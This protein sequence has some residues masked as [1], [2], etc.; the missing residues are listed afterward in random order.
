MNVLMFS[1]TGCLLLAWLASV[2]AIRRGYKKIVVGVCEQESLHRLKKLKLSYTLFDFQ[3]ITSSTTKAVDLIAPSVGNHT[4]CSDNGFEYARLNSSDSALTRFQSW[5]G[6]VQWMCSI[7]HEANVPEYYTTDATN[8]TSFP[9]A[10]RVWPL[11]NAFIN[12]YTVTI[13]NDRQEMIKHVAP[14]KAANLPYVLEE[15]LEHVT[16]GV[17]RLYG[18]AFQGKLLSLRC[19]KHIPPITVEQNP[20]HPERGH[21]RLIACGKDITAILHDMF[22]KAGDYSGPFCA[23]IMLDAQRRPHFT[24]FHA[25]LCQEVTGND[26][27]FISAFVPLAAALQLRQY[28]SAD[29]PAWFKERQVY[30][31]ILSVE[32]RVLQLGGGERS[33]APVEASRFDP[34]TELSGID[35]HQK[36]GYHLALQDAIMS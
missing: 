9:V 14:V 2:S 1:I 27:L 29:A 25:R 18:A 16:A 20:A 34:D 19:V 23:S 10:L 33:G 21:T 7:G 32:R 35:Y 13:L 3:S 5:A 30:K 15:R 4:S 17:A 28:D 12:N 36:I 11:G 26:E 31:H 22:A 24:E 8:V 6:W